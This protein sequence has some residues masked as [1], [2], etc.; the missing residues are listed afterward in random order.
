MSMAKKV[1]DNV[2]HMMIVLFFAPQPAALK[3]P[4]A[5]LPHALLKALNTLVIK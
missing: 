5:N 1:E 4:V 2:L 3:N